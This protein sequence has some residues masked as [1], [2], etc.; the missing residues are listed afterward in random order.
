MT[1]REKIIDNGAARI[2][3]DQASS[4]EA[5]LEIAREIAAECPT[6][7]YLWRVQVQKSDR[8]RR[9]SVRVWFRRNA[10]NRGPE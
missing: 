6:G 9:S 5:G 4:P 7:Y 1:H 8:G 2:V 10:L 3:D